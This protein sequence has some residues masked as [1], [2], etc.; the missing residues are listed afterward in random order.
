MA[1]SSLMNNVRKMLYHNALHLPT[2]KDIIL[3]L[4]T[5]PDFSS[6]CEV[7]IPPLLAGV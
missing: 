7:V 6:R 5:V 2:D 4:N 3:E 1:Y